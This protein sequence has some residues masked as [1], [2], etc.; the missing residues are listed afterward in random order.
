MLLPACLARNEIAIPM[1]A[2]TTTSSWVYGQLR[3]SVLSW[4][5]GLRKSCHNRAENAFSNDDTV[6]TAAA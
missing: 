2:N 6:E 1:K 3:L 4:N 5:T